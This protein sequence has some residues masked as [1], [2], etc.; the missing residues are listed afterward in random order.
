MERNDRD[1]TPGVD[2]RIVMV[3]KSVTW[4]SLAQQISMKPL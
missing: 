3:A 2:V 1:G 4:N